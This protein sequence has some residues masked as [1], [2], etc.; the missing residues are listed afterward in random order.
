MKA[1][2][3]PVHWPNVRPSALLDIAGIKVGIVG[4]MTIDA[5]RATLLT[6]VHGLRVAPLAPTVAA[7]AGEAASRGCD[8][9]DRRRARGRRVRAN[10][11]TPRIC[12]RA[13]TKRRSFGSRAACRA[14]SST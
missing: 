9:R 6:N 13:T 8:A 10:S 7:E 5:L 11:R 12:R 2:G 1:T 3:E 4:I 14:G